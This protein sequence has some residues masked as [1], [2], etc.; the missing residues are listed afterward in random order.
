MCRNRV[1]V[2]LLLDHGLDVDEENGNAL[3]GAVTSR[4]IALAA[5]LLQHGANPTLRNNQC[6][7]YAIRNGTLLLARML[8]ERGANVNTHIGLAVR[9]GNAVSA[10]ENC[11]CF[12]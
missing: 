7:E 11:S 12:G 8:I 10:P 3:L 1:T 2:A 4:D 5:L 6:I 9:T